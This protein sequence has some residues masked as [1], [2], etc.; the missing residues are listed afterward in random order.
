MRADRRSDVRRPVVTK[1]AKSVPSSGS[2]A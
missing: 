1:A 2:A